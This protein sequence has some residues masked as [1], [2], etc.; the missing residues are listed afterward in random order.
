MPKQ[1]AP[2]SYLPLAFLAFILVLALVATGADWTGGGPGPVAYADASG[3]DGGSAESGDVPPIIVYQTT[4]CGYCRKA[5]SLLEDL[6]AVY[7]AKDIER[8]R[9]AAREYQK[10]GRG[11]RGVPLIDYDGRIVRGYDER[12]IREMARDQKERARESA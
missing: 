5:R 6:D 7:I 10:K 1:Q 12:A 11:G 8:D 9:E 2:T 4:W 3:S